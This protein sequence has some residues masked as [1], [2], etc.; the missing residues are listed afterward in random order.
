M[1][2]AELN[3]LI[4]ANIQDLDGASHHLEYV[5]QHEVADAIDETLLALLREAGWAGVSDW[6]E[7]TVWAAPKTWHRPD[8]GEDDYIAY[9]EFDVD[10]KQ[11]DERDA[12]RLTQLVGKA[13]AR[14]GFRWVQHG[15]TNR[16]WRKAVGARPSE[17]QELRSLGFEYRERD[18]TFF[19]PIIL[20][21]GELAAALADED[22]P[23]ALGSFARSLAVLQT[24]V[25]AFDRLLLNAPIE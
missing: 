22:I 14:V 13:H 20:D 4:V 11:L 16:I 3:A 6:K 12:Y 5:L 19:L 24:S 18:G 21:A 15:V 7:E 8:E 25:G 9:F 2:Q 10:D 17:I 23:A 1:S